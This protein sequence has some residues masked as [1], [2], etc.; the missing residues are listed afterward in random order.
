MPTYTFDNYRYND[1]YYYHL[2]LGSSLEINILS[3]DL[4][5]QHVMTAV[6]MR[7]ACLMPMKIM[8]LA[9]R[10]QLPLSGMSE[11]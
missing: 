7:W 1:H 8:I 6:M 2:E 5:F 10:I 3:N 9:V 4:L 11:Q